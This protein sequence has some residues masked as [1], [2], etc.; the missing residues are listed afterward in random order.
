M[1]IGSWVWDGVRIVYEYF[2]IQI[3]D[4]DGLEMFYIGLIMVVLIFDFFV[5]KDWKLV[6]LLLEESVFE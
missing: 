5:I 4:C 6:V 3:V 2:D 1:V